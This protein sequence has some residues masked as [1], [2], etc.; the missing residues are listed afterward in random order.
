MSKIVPFSFQDKNKLQTHQP[1]NFL[2]VYDNFIGESTTEF[3]ETFIRCL[4]K[5]FFEAGYQ[6]GLHDERKQQENVNDAT[7]I[8]HIHPV[9]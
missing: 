7:G 6:K 3:L 9:R 8:H 4:A 2:T 5:D 1:E